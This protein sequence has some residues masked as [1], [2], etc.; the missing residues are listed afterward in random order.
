MQIS[1]DLS[2]IEAIADKIVTT[3]RSNVLLFYGEMGAGKTTLIKAIA[4]KIGVTDTISSPTF[5]IVNEYVTGND[6]LIYHFD[7]YRITNQEEALDMGFEEYIYNGD[8]IFIEWPDNIS[9]FL[10]NEAD[11]IKIEKQKANKRAI[12]IN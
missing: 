11:I 10:P 5:S 2:D 1:Y 6:Q 7:F 12:S 9:K 4:K 8:W 3:V